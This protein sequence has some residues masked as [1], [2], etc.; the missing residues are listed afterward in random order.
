MYFQQVRGHAS[1]RGL[2]DE[3][4]TSQAGCPPSRIRGLHG[5]QTEVKALAC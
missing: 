2:Y 1:S 3:S 4:S 5:K